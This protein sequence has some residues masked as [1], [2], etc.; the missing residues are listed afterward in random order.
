MRNMS[1]W[2]RRDDLDLTSDDIGA[3]LD[4]GE[5]V[6]IAA[7]ELPHAAVLVTA[8]RTF[9]GRTRVLAPSAGS[10]SSGLRVTRQPV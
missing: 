4:A 7:P 6:E 2:G 5:P 1:E 8:L 3:M 9:G 10:I